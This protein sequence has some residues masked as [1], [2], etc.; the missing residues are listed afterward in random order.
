MK[1]K[2]SISRSIF[3]CIDT[4]TEGHSTSLQ[5]AAV[6]ISKSINTMIQLIFHVSL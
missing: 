2:Y 6:I 4:V 5:T 1:T 3:T